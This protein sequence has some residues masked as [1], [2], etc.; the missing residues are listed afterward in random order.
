[1][2]ISR[3]EHTEADFKPLEV[4][5]LHSVLRSASFDIVSLRFFS[6]HWVGFVSSFFSLSLFP[7][8]GKGRQKYDWDV[9]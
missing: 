8:L 3:R 2:E 7:M 4:H 5:S 9:E 1:M 6:S